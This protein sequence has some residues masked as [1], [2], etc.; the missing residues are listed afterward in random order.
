MT[1]KTAA[2]EN[3]DPDFLKVQKNHE[4]RLNKEARQVTAEAQAQLDKLELVRA[5]KK[6]FSG[7]QGKK[8]LDHL[9]AN[10]GLSKKMFNQDDRLTSYNLGMQAVVIDIND[11]VNSK[12]KQG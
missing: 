3:N 1:K 11:I 4:Q 5:Y 2:N 10:Y 7:E 8:V 6:V 12:I 9:F